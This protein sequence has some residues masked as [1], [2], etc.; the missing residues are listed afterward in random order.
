LDVGIGYFGNAA[1]VDDF[2][3]WI[4]SP[5]A[6]V[7]TLATPRANAP[8]TLLMTDALPFAPVAIAYSATGAGPIPTALGVVG[9]SFPIEIFLET[10]ADAS[11]RVEIPFAPL[12]PVSGVMLHTQALDALAPALSNYFTVV[13]L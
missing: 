2:R 3:A 12:G 7:Y 13:V 5:T 6:P 4:G 1:T 11:G 8:T 10:N 9:L